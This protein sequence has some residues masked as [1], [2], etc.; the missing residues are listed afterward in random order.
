MALTANREV[1]HY[2]DQELRSLRVAA[3]AHVYKGAIVGVSPAGWA[4]PLTAGDLFA[5][6]AYEEADNAGGLDGD[7]SVRVYT[8]GDFGHALSGATIVNTGDAVYASDDET[9]T[10]TAAGNSFV[11][12]AV[13]VP[14]SGTVIVR[15]DGFRAGP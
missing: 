13:D 1:D 7:V 10:F 5:G 3:G 12:R 9:L 2:I 15:L 4:R 14:A 8:L 11:G 6:I